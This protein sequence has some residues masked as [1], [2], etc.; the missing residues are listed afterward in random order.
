MQRRKVYPI[1]EDRAARPVSI[2]EKRA[3]WT[4]Q[5]STFLPCVFASLRLCV[6][7]FRLSAQLTALPA[8]H[9]IR[10]R[11][12]GGIV[13]VAQL[14]QPLAH[15]AEGAAQ[16]KIGSA[17]DPAVAVGVR[18]ANG[19][20]CIPPAENAAGGDQF[21]APAGTALGWEWRSA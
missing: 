6:R 9:C 15:P 2:I 14:R 12:D 21:L 1:S 17:V 7:L 4:L 20:L 16:K 10:H 13:V 19:Q 18:A 8:Q 5:N 3:I 11:G